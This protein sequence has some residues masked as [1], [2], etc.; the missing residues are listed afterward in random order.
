MDQQEFEREYQEKWGIPTGNQYLRE[1]MAKGVPMP[2]AIRNYQ[3]MA[4][5]HFKKLGIVA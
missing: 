3:D 4:N 2:V 1:Q 5:A